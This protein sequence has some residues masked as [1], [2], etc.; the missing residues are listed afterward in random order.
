MLDIYRIRKNGKIYGVF[1]LDQIHRMIAKGSLLPSDPIQRNSEEWMAVSDLI[2]NINAFNDTTKSSSKIQKSDQNDSKQSS[3]INKNDTQTNQTS[4]NAY[5]AQQT[6]TDPTPLWIWIVWISPFYI[7]RIILNWSALGMNYRKYN[8]LGFFFLTCLSI[9]ICTITTENSA[10]EANPCMPYAPMMLFTI[11]V[12]LF[13]VNKQKQI[14]A[15]SNIILIKQTI[16]PNLLDLIFAVIILVTL[17]ETTKIV[18]QEHLKEYESLIDFVKDEPI[19]DVNLSITIESLLYSISEGN[20]PRKVKWTTYQWNNEYR[21]IRATGKCKLKDYNMKYEI[22]FIPVHH[23]LFDSWVIHSKNIYVK[24]NGN[25]LQ[26]KQK[27]DFLKS[28]VSYAS[29]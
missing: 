13:E 26:E 29:R 16:I 21:C 20:S 23:Q 3:H 10:F 6:L 22:G 4:T 17:V 12:Q 8:I 5:I 15:K 14:I 1:N 7:Y 25:L 19:A 27:N 2:P 24:I 28:A 11:L 18:Y 9:I